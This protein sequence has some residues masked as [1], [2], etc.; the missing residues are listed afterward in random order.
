MN[1]N[2]NPIFL[3]NVQQQIH[4]RK[5][6]G[7]IELQLWSKAMEELNLLP[8]TVADNPKVHQLRA[9]LY[10]TENNFPAAIS[11]ISVVLQQEP[12][13]ISAWITY[14]WCLKR[15]D[16]VELAA[17]AMEKA[18]IYSPDE[19]TLTY[20]LACYLSIIG[21]KEKA[22]ALLQQATTL[23]PMFAVMAKSES[24]FDNVRAT[25]EFTRIVC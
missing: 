6:E 5:L 18:L 25:D 3:S 7:F 23:V 13:N 22:L 20:N 8:S 19:P 11:E 2:N 16:R 15:T 10:R 21:Q 14:A 9:E 17:Q 24:D 4:L 1:I 12:H